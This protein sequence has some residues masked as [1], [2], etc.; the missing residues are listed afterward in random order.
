MKPVHAA[1]IYA[2]CI[3]AGSA[4]GLAAGTRGTLGIFCV[5]AER[6]VRAIQT[7]Y[8]VVRE[9]PRAAIGTAR[10]VVCR[11]VI[12]SGGACR[13]SVAVFVSSRVAQVHRAKV[14]YCIVAIPNRGRP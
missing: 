10:I 3:I 7:I 1:A 12:C 6:P 14:G 4:I 5:I 2:A 11:A 9:F 8:I 13:T